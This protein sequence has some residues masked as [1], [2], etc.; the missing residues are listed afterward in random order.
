M[1]S[2]RKY[3]SELVTGWEVAKVQAIV[4]ETLDSIVD[5]LVFQEAVD[6]IAMHKELGHVVIVISTSGT[7]VVE[8]IAARL[9]A[10]IAIGTQVE[11]RR[12]I[13]DLSI[14]ALERPA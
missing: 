4:S 13:R 1:E 11:E 12:A 6:L 5:P 3:I 9:G 7:D 10:D 2:M 8:P 14:I